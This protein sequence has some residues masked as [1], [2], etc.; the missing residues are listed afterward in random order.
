MATPRQRGGGPAGA[1]RQPPQQLAETLTVGAPEANYGN[2]TNDR[3]CCEPLVTATE[4]VAANTGYIA[5]EIG[6]GTDKI[7]QRLGDVANNLS[8]S[9]TNLV[10]ATNGVRDTLNRLPAL[11]TIDRSVT[12]RRAD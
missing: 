7:V 1:S 11:T 5:T 2:V 10:T 12:L 9:A 6:A 4:G 3:H 8:T